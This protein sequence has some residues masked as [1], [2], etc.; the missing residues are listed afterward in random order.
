[1]QV[2]NMLDMFSPANA[3]SSQWSQGPAWSGC[4]QRLQP[5]AV[6]LSQF[7]PPRHASSGSNSLSFLS[8]GLC[9]C[10]SF[11]WKAL[12]LTLS[13]WLSPLLGPNLNVTGSERTSPQGQCCCLFH[14]LLSVTLPRCL[15]PSP[16]S[17]SASSS[18]SSL[19]LNTN[20][21]AC[22]PV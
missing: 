3:N 2:A 8:L 4:C 18:F 5:C 9:T 14:N 17:S 10:C 21:L 19:A 22:L 7:R 16:S 20:Y 11:W 6:E 12:P 15:C 13:V 1:M